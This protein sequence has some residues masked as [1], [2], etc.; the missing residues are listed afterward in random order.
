MR[1]AHAALLALVLIAPAGAVASAAEVREFEL[2]NGFRIL[3]LEDRRAPV[4]TT[5]MWYRVGSIDEYRGVTGISH[6]LEHMMFKGTEALETGEFSRRI[7]ERGGRDN[8]FTGRDYTGYH[9]HLAAGNLELPIR[10]EA[11]RMRNLVLDEEEFRQE[12]RVVR[13]ERRQRVDDRPRSLLWERVRAAAFPSSPV[14]QPVIGWESD[15][16]VMAV[17]DLQRWYDQW[18]WPNNASLIV[19]GDV[20]PDEVH[21]L[22]REHFGGIEANDLPR[23]LNHAE[24]EPDGKV[25]LEVHAPANLPY[26][27]LVWRVPSLGTLDDPADAWALRVAAGVLDEGRS[28]RIERR[29]VREQR[30]AAGAGAGYSM[31]TRGETLFSLAGTPAADHEV[32]DLEAALLAEVE[33]L[34]EGEIDEAELDRVKVNIRARDVF[35]RDSIGGRARMLGILESTGIG[36]EMW[37]AYLEGIEAVTTEDVRRVTREYLVD[38]RLTVG[39]LVPEGLAPG[40]RPE[41]PA[42]PVEGDGH[43]DH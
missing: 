6:A 14:R 21:D 43:V 2:D 4:F 35:G 31:F 32:A 36:H 26:V 18:Y 24:I 15:L 19:V 40:A 34:K 12:M 20:D 9:Q 3:V 11:E 37:D 38:R 17:D 42:G 10:M 16:E 30:V 8:A 13:E 5:Q 22:A 28:A 7:A 41:D 1:I 23:R 25:R 33:A 27:A 39:T 29:L